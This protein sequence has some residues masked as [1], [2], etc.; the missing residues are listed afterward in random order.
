MRA[1]L[2]LTLLASGAAAQ[3]AG[4]PVWTPPPPGTYPE[5]MAITGVVQVSGRELRSRDDRLAAFVDGEVRGVAGSTLVGSRRVFFLS[6]AGD[7]TEGVLTFR[8]YNALEDRV[9]EVQPEVRFDPLHPLGSVA[10]PVVWTPFWDGGPPAWEV[11]PAAFS[12]SMTVTGRVFRSE[13]VVSESGTLVGAFLDGELRGSAPLQ[14]AGVSGWLAFVTVY[15]DPADTGDLAF[16]VYLPSADRTFGVTAAVP[17]EASTVVGSAGRPLALPIR[18]GA[19]LSGPEG[20]QMLAPPGADAT[21]TAVL[22]PLWTQGFPDSDSPSGTA[23]VLRYREPEGDFAAVAGVDEAWPRGEGRF[24]YVFEDDDPRTSTVDGGFPKVLPAVG[25]GPSGSFAF[26]LTR[27]E[28]NGAPE[29]SGWNLLGNPFDTAIDWDLGWTRVDVSNSVYVWDAAY[30]GGGYRVW[31]GSVGSLADGVIPRGLAFWARASTPTA[32]L[33]V[34]ADARILSASGAKRGAVAVSSLALRLAS[35]GRPGLATEAWVTFQEGAAD[36]LDAYDAWVLVPLVA[37]YVTLGTAAASGDRLFAVDARGGEPSGIVSVPLAA[38]AV[39]GGVAA[40]DS[41]VLTWPHLGVPET[42]GLALLDTETGERVDLRTAA[43]YRFGVAE[44]APTG[45]AGPAGGE[46]QRAAGGLPVRFRLELASGIATAT[47]SG[48]TPG[49]SLAP[50][51][52]TPP[53]VRSRSATRCLGRG[54]SRSWSTT[55]S[56]A[57]SPS[58]P[59][60]STPRGG[61]RRASTSGLWRR[62]CTWRGWPPAA[63]SSCAAS[64]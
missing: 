16:R 40:A 5:S 29:G 12:A 2:L 3:S 15:G 46:P 34:P 31:N 25:L 23:N 30:L 48:A 59:A 28:G 56:A 51:S 57:G 45:G 6:V 11:D 50:P 35:V 47:A 18:P 53:E 17:F 42:W 62:G 19:T 55:R 37:D 36:G 10:A 52:P 39:A 61:T 1:L 60:A 22:G 44:Q 21:V 54:T 14:S 7:G 24:V 20:W 32:E 33:R 38:G 49:L 63:P 9:V 64:R 4:P 41:L 8:A 58:P 27:T 43:E 26:A 13:E